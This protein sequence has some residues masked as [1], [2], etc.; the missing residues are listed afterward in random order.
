MKPVRWYVRPEARRNLRFG[1]NR[2]DA[3]VWAAFTYTDRDP[4]GDPI[5][6]ATPTFFK[7]RIAALT[8]AHRRV[9]S[10]LR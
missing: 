1:D 5:P 7:G 10:G 8:F 2:R 4:Q 3:I 9:R 6:N